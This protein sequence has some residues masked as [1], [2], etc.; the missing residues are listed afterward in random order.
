[1]GDGVRLGKIIG[2]CCTFKDGTPVVNE[3]FAKMKANKLKMP[4]ILKLIV[5]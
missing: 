2:D 4:N 3:T 5:A 1:M